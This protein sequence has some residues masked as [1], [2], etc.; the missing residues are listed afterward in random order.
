MADLPAAVREA[1]GVRK[2]RPDELPQ[3]AAVLRAAFF[4]DPA[5]AWLMN[6]ESRRA[7][8]LER[9]F[10]LF[11]ERIW[12]RQDECYTTASAVGA[13]VWELPDQWKQGALEQLR[14]MPGLL[15]IYRGTTPRLLRALAAMEAGHPE[16]PHYY[17][18]FAGVSPDWQ[19]R[20]IGAA[21]LAPVL[22]RCDTDRVPAYLEATTPRNR[23]LYERHGFSVT[24]E[25]R[26]GKG[27]PPLWR[28]WRPAGG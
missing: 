25:F 27:S 17:L 12:Y 15:S 19:G 28:M 3:I 4:D 22:S 9:A 5:V 13:A 10:G 7:S 18:P 26:L 2:V 8:R 6:D 1:Q 23:A 16:A 11:L 21:L 24:A 14:L 20:G